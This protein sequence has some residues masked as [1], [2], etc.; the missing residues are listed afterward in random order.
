MKVN[1]FIYWQVIKSVDRGH[2]HYTFAV[3]TFY[4]EQKALRWGNRHCNEGEFS[5][6][7]I[8]TFKNGFI[9]CEII[10]NGIQQ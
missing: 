7:K 6:L 4:D 3:K 10:K 8:S 9:H 5:V 1:N 2:K